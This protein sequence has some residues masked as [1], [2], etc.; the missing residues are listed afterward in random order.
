M[1]LVLVLLPAFAEVL[2]GRRQDPA[3][4][5]EAMLAHIEL[6]SDVELLR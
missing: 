5:T 1:V 2:G 4:A 6:V 3:A